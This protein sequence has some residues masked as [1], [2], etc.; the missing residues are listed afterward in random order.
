MIKYILAFVFTFS[1]ILVFGQNKIMRIRYVEKNIL[2]GYQFIDDLD[3]Y[4]NYSK[5]SRNINQSLLVASELVKPSLYAKNP[6][7]LIKDYNKRVLLFNVKYGILRDTLNKIKWDIIPGTKTIIGYNC[8]MAEATFRGREYRAYFCPEIPI[9][10]GPFKFQ[11]L[12]GLILEIYSKDN[13]IKYSAMEIVSNET[14][15]LDVKSDWF[16]N[17]ISFHEYAQKTK[18]ELELMT[19]KIESRLPPEEQGKIKFSFSEEEIEVFSF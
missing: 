18:K 12:P 17:N 7:T 13:F 2:H 11:G 14:G 19:K 15:K 8:K 4:E 3:L 10:D 1:S 16:D 9:S 5:F 6:Y